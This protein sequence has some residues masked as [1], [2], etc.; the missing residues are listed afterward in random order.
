MRILSEQT[1]VCSVL[2]YLHNFHKTF[3]LSIKLKFIAEN[4][5]KD[6]FFLYNLLAFLMWREKNPKKKTKS[7][8]K[9]K[10][11]DINIHKTNPFLSTLLSS[12]SLNGIF[13]HCYRLQLDGSREMP[14]MG[15][16]LDTPD[17]HKYPTL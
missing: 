15:R 11:L 7:T 4:S 5:Q 2:N 6:F 3:P 10:H 14:E 12:H 17:S 1:I 13:S 8:R 9:E 16:K